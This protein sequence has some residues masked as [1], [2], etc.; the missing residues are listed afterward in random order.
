ME[1]E[2]VRQELEENNKDLEFRLANETK[3]LRER[4][5]SLQAEADRAKLG[6]VQPARA[7]SSSEPTMNEDLA[8]KELINRIRYQQGVDQVRWELCSQ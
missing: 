6:F 2:K 3:A 8:G 4:L 1:A 5:V 7:E